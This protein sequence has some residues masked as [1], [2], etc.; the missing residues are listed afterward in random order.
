MSA[1]PRDFL[2]AA[3]AELDA[4]RRRRALVER[5]AAAELERHARRFFG[6]LGIILEVEQ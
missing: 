3:A 1:G 5:R 2:Q 6:E 4:D